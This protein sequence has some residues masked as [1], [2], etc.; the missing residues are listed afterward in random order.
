MVDLGAAL[1]VPFPAIAR[2]T[3]LELLPDNPNGIFFDKLGGSGTI[4]GSRAAIFTCPGGVGQNCTC[5]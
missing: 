5:L 1:I 2:M 4:L 3:V